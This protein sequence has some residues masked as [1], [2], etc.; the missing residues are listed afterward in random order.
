[1]AIELMIVSVIVSEFIG[2]IM[3]ITSFFI[4]PSTKIRDPVYY[5]SSNIGGLVDTTNP[6]IINQPGGEKITYYKM[7]KTDD[8][9]YKQIQ[10]HIHFNKLSGTDVGDGKFLV[11][12]YDSDAK[13]TLITFIPY[14]PS[15]SKIRTAK[16]LFILGLVF[17][18]AIPVMSII[19]L[20]LL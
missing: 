18:T 13:K 15:N 8:P 16:I 5:T 12:G 17:M 4:N 20:S 9:M 19:L 6:I 2:F 3:L 14:Y 7:T 1:M 10:E 11:R